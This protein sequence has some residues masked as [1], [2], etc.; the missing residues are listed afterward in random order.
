[1]AKR[2]KILGNAFIIEDTITSNIEMDEPAKD[3]YFDND[4]LNSG[5][6]QI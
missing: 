5:Y 1:M 2:I 6:I 3:V 4:I